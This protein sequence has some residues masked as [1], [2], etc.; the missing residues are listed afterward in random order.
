MISIELNVGIRGG[1]VGLCTALQVGRSR[2][3]SS[4]PNRGLHPI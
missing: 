1:E 4:P 3:P 2:G